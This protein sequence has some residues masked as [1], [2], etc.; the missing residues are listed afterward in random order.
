MRLTLVIDS[1][2]KPPRN[3]PG[4]TLLT[5]PRNRT[6]NRKYSFAHQAK[7]QCHHFIF[8]SRLF[9]PPIHHLGWQE[10]NENAF[11]QRNSPVFT[12]SFHPIFF[13]G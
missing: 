6:E 5:H 11:P 9:L 2:Q 7:P 3:R 8:I 4:R 10:G 13:K 12:T 1:M